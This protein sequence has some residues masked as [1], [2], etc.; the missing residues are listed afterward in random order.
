MSTLNEVSRIINELKKFELKLFYSL[1]NSHGNKAT[2]QFRMRIVRF[3]LTN[4]NPKEE[5]FRK[6]FSGISIRKL[7]ESLRE[8]KPFLKD[9][10]VSSYTIHKTFRKS[11]F[12]RNKFSVL[13]D[14]PYLMLLRK[15]G[16]IYESD[17]ILDKN[18]GICIRYELFEELL[19]YYQIKLDA[20]YS[21]IPNDNFKEI[22]NLIDVAEK[23]SRNLRIS[24][25]A[26]EEYMSISINKGNY[27]QSDKAFSALER[28]SNSLNE[29]KS[30]RISMYFHLMNM[31]LLLLK[32]SYEKALDSGLKLLKLLKD[33]SFLSTNNR[34]G[35][36]YSYLAHNEL[37]ALNFESSIHYSNLAK[38]N[39][40]QNTLNSISLND[41]YIRSLLCL[42]KFK[43]AKSV[44]DCQLNL[45]VICA[46]PHY[47]SKFNY[48]SAILSFLQSDFD[49]AWKML[50]I[51]HELEKDKEGWRVWLSIMRIICQIEREEY[52]DVGFQ[53][54]SFRKYIKR[55]EERAEIRSRDKLIFKILEELYKAEFEFSKLMIEQ[56]SQL[57]KLRSPDGKYCW[58]SRSPELI[59]FHDWFDTKEK[60]IPYQPDFEKYRAK[61][62]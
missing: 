52:L 18:I 6:G 42:N 36:V 38:L 3:F 25:Q 45:S 50:S 21:F 5:D 20:N 58:D 4:P 35:F 48:Y 41:F 13:S 39:F 8:L 17:K 54:D 28:I 32:K 11:D 29:T 56:K 40:E 33:N 34:V 1:I 62:K 15:K 14:I 59:L 9:T 43:S 27:N 30:V 53:L 55:W 61:N 26:Y 47:E 19:L 12:F 10:L 51:H 7:N 2:R 49:N 22:A 31:E 44:L 16:L 60:N 37:C 57:D 23:D 24:K 46:F